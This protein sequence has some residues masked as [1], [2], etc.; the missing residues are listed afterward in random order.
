MDTG[1]LDKFANLSIKDVQ[2]IR[3]EIEI[4]GQNGLDSNDPE[5]KYSLQSLQGKYSGLHFC[6][7]MYAAFKQFA[8]R[9]DVGID[10]SKEYEAAREMRP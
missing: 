9:E 1:A 2:A 5:Q 6:S 4:M 8:P 10:F 3:V 7:I